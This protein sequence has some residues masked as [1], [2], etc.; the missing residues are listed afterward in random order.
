MNEGEVMG[1]AQAGREKIIRP[2]SG[3]SPAPGAEEPVPWEEAQEWTK[4]VPPG[5]VRRHLHWWVAAGLGLAVVLGFG[6]QALVGRVRAASP[7]LD[8]QAVVLGQAPAVSTLQHELVREQMADPGPPPPLV[9]DAGDKTRQAE[10]ERQHQIE[11]ARAQQ[12]AQ[13]A[14]SPI[15]AIGGPVAQP[16]PLSTPAPGSTSPPAEPGSGMG[17]LPG[18][19]SVPPTIPSLGL[20]LNGVGAL[21]ALTGMVASPWNPTPAVPGTASQPPPAAVRSRQNTTPLEPVQP[22]N[23]A[24]VLEGTV[25]PAVLITQINSDL[26]GLITAQITEDVYDSI[27]GTLLAVPKGSRLIGQFAARL[28]PGQERLMASFHRL[29]L[30][31]G[32]SFQLE[33]MVASDAQG[34]SGMQDEVDNRFW[35]R[36]GGQFMTAGLAQIIAQPTGGVTV[37]GGMG[38]NLTTDAA[39]QILVN[40]ASIGFAGQAAIGPVIIIKKGYPFSLLVNRDMDFASLASSPAEMSGASLKP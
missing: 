35:K 21:P 30:P 27:D 23:H 24:L 14:A 1:M 17:M 38:N 32:V 3:G 15:L 18:S 5:K 36:L 40:T 4:G 16:V 11:L 19:A 31:S 37:L 33:D 12:A 6:V 26:P 7:S 13:I 25:M 8:A 34:Q 2:G 22:A 20:G 28:L 9:D 39:G 29:I 10:Q